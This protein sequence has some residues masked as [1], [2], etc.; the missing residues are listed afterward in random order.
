[1]IKWHYFTYGRLFDKDEDGKLSAS[2]LRE[3]MI[4]LGEGPISEEEFKHF[5][6]VS[7]N[8]VLGLELHN[9]S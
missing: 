8:R 3:I 6:K 5:V 2:E 7:L 1:M 9:L 4:N